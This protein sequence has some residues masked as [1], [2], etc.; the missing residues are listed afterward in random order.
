MELSEDFLKILQMVIGII[1]ILAIFMIFISYEVTVSYSESERRVTLLADALL[2]SNCL[3]ALDLNNN[4]I[5]GLFLEENL[6]RLASDSSCIRRFYNDGKITVTAGET[7]DIQVGAA[8]TTTTEFSIAVRLR[9]GEVIPGK[10]K[11][12]L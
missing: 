11:V 4:P 12:S 9:T 7:W 2:G 8:G 1:G 10:M 6:D 3:T 5:K